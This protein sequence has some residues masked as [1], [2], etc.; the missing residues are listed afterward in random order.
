MLPNQNEWGSLPEAFPPQ[1]RQGNVGESDASWISPHQPRPV[2]TPT[3]TD[4][5]I[6][7]GRDSLLERK[8]LDKVLTRL[9]VAQVPQYQPTPAHE[10]MSLILII[11]C[12]PDG[13]PLAAVC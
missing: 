5:W 10:T 13:T 2:A 6:P 1:T 4:G 11:L 8:L 7:L 12:T 3:R 9:G